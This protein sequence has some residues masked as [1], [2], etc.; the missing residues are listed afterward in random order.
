MRR[1]ATWLIVL[2][3]FLAGVLAGVLGSRQ[4][5]HY[6]LSQFVKKGHPAHSEIILRE[7]SKEL[8]LTD[9][10]RSEVRAIL[11]EMDGRIDRL[12]ETFDPQIRA[13]FDDGFPR[14]RERMSGEQVK[15]FD[16]FLEKLKKRAG[17]PRRPPPL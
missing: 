14:I 4:Y 1:T 6:R 15:K 9:R 3:V 5:T 12:R 10:Q 17:P 8:D 7:M 2:L 11:E 13:V 16:T